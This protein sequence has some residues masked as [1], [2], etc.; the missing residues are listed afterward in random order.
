MDDGKI[1]VEEFVEA[2]LKTWKTRISEEREKRE[3]RLPVITVCMEP[4]SGGSIVAQEIAK[5]LDF[6]LF[7]HDIVNEIAKS[8]HISSQV[9]ET[10]EKERL[11]GI[12]DFISSLI[13]SKMLFR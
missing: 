8:S 13:K 6:D 10:L 12:E 4:G 3:A 5:Q 9:I 1:L 7:H 2:Q 11:I